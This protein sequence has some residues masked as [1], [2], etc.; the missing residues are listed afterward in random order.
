MAE[1]DIDAGVLCKHIEIVERVKTYDAAQYETTED[2]LVRRC[3][4]QFTRQSGT[5]SLRQGA[6]LGT[7]KV[8]FLIR[9]PPV[10]ISRLYYVKYAGD[11]YSI[12]YV[13][14]YGDRGGFTE[15][16]AELQ[17]LGGAE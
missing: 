2:K 11:Y 14:H 9:T 4:A 8:R 15:I 13:N 17:E 12:T 10:E 5:E 1:L 16:L 7:V 3:W 6:D